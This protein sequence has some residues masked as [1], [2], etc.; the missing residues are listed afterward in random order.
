MMTEV[1]FGVMEKGL[2]LLQLGGYR[3]ELFVFLKKIK[4]EFFFFTVRKRVLKDH[5]PLK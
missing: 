2:N 5:Q 1:R 4:I 3:S